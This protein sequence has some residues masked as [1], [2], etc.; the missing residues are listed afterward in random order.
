VNGKASGT[1]ARRLELQQEEWM[2]HALSPDPRPSTPL[3]WSAAGGT[4]HGL[5]LWWH[6]RRFT[7]RSDARAHRW[8]IVLA[9]TFTLGL[10][11]LP[12]IGLTGAAGA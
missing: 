9:L 4:I 12:L 5:A 10:C 3:G 1:A 8:T 11:V 6:L 2:A 7:H